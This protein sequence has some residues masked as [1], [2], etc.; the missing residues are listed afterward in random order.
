[1]GTANAAAE[2][3][4]PNRDPLAAPVT[5]QP[6]AMGR[7]H[8]ATKLSVVD[9][10]QADVGGGQRREKRLGQL[11]NVPVKRTELECGPAGLEGGPTIQVVER[12]TI[13][14]ELPRE[15]IVVRSVEGAKSIGE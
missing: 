13:G 5:R 3:C 12:S 8:L 10:R 11:V 9:P 2:R 1:M 7:F 4:R 14:A 15:P 6:Q